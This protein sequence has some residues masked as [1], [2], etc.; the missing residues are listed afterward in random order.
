MM[1]LAT[2]SV[3]RV[4]LS[5]ALSLL[6][7]CGDSKE[8]PAEDGEADAGPR[9]RPPGEQCLRVDELDVVPIKGIASDGPI[10]TLVLD[11]SHFY[12]SSVAGV[13]RA[14]R[15]GGEVETLIENE[16]PDPFTKTPLWL[17]SKGLLTLTDAGI[18]EVPKAGGEPVTR[19]PVAQ[20]GR[21]LSIV[22][23]SLVLVADRVYFA[24]A[25]DG[26]G[27]ARLFVADL[28]TGV[29]TELAQTRAEPDGAALIADE[30]IWTEPTSDEASPY[31]SVLKAV[32]RA[33]GKVRTLPMELGPSRVA[34]SVLGQDDSSVF[35]DVGLDLGEDNSDPSALSVAG[36]YRQ[37]PG[38]GKALKLISAAPVGLFGLLTGAP[39]REVVRTKDGVV[40][41]GGT[42]QR[43]ELY[44]LK[45][46]ATEPTKLFCLSLA[47]EVVSSVAAADGKVYLALRDDAGTRILS[48]D[49]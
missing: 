1:C 22:A 44:T 7:A 28:A 17:T 10:E 48:H 41:R 15:K 29:A 47:S 31:V 40:I 35:L 25:I 12:F 37:R 34:F 39:Q 3:R 43:A 49:D 19:V 33:G 4:P 20:G 16:L 8:A 27:T 38:G 30:L 46:S 11:A 23:S 2:L 21:T 6:L 24:D 9:G 18:V 42:L 32:P 14:P 5:F 26:E 45:G 36:L 13:Y